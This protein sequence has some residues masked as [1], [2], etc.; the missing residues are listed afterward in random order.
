MTNNEQNKIMERLERKLDSVLGNLEKSRFRDY[1]EYVNDR[2][3]LLKNTF[4]LGI[5]RGLG[6][7]IGFT[8]LGALLW[9]V[10]QALAQSSI[11]LLGDLLAE[12]VRIVKE[13]V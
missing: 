2:K 1:I 9:Y 7:A 8:I 5:V 10:L 6:S 12:L 4:L 11:P 3:R 13:R